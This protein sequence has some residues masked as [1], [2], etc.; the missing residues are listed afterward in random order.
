MPSK[1]LILAAVQARTISSANRRAK[2][3]KV[4]MDHREKRPAALTQ[5][6]EEHQRL[7]SGKQKMMNLTTLFE[8]K[9]RK[10]TT[11][12]DEKKH[13]NKRKTKK[14][15]REITQTLGEKHKDEKTL[16]EETK[17]EKTRGEIMFTLSFRVA[18]FVVFC[19][20]FSFFYVAFYVL[21]RCA[22]FRVFFCLF[23][24]AF[25]SCFS[26]A[27]GLASVS[28]FVF[29]LGVFFVISSFRVASFA[30]ERR[31]INHRRFG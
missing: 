20:Y 1:S 25:L 14:T 9:K 4:K 26:P 3:N 7:P 31:K 18:S 17:P 8:K 28:C 23:S 29:S 16:G 19:A 21:C 5:S 6:H 22:F 12:K 13:A 27:F 24:L 30:S 10:D 11:R 2:H 15:S